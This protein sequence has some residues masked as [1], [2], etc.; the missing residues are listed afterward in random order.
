[1]ENQ[2]TGNQHNS[3]PTSFAEAAQKGEE[4]LEEKAQ[5]Y[6]DE[7]GVG[8]DSSQI[9]SL[10]R[11]QPLEAAGIAAAA[12]FVVGGGLAGAAGLAV[13][14]IVARTAVRST[15]SDLLGVARKQFGGGASRRA[16]ANA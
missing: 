10:I 11:D 3:S 8:I 2:K 12:G 7:A 5:E 6:L 4:R 13:L 1:M 9:L 15:V 16:R 14:G